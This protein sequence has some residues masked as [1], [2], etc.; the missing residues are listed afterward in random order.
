MGGSLR[1]GSGRRMRF[2]G[3]LLKWEIRRLVTY[4]AVSEKKA[5]LDR[6]YGRNIIAQLVCTMDSNNF[7]SSCVLR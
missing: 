7:F 6:R 1:R 2:E 5:F 4:M 3:P